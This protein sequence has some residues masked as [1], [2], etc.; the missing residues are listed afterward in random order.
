[1]DNKSEYAARFMAVLISSPENMALVT[2]AARDAGYPATKFAAMAACDY[3][4]ALIDE[5]KQ[6]GE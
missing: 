4:E 5:L 1:M 2:K 6:R 3:A